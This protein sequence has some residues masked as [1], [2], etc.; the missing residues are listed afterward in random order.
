MFL[1]SLQTERLVR[2]LED[3]L[4]V[5]CTMK[6]NDNFLN[7]NI[8]KE[9]FNMTKALTEKY[10]EKLKVLQETLIKNSVLKATLTE[11]ET[12]LKT[13]DIENK[14]MVKKNCFKVGEPQRQK[15]IAHI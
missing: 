10:E 1:E 7:K 2:N 9:N 4:M 3:Q 5:N 13:F 14:Q 6:F 8:F 15:S 12:E 11:L